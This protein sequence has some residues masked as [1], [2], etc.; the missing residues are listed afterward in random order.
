[1]YVVTGTDLLFLRILSGLDSGYLLQYY[2]Q[3]SSLNSTELIACFLLFRVEL[4]LIDF[5]FSLTS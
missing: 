4:D 1:M 5:H 2:T 3:K